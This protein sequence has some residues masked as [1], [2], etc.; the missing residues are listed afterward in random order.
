MAIAMGTFATAA[1]S[2]SER[3]RT[4]AVTGIVRRR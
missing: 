3:T 4:V 2:V 1:M